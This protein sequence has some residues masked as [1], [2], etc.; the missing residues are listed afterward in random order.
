MSHFVVLVIG[1]NLE[2]KLAP[3]NEEKQVKPYIDTKREEVEETFRKIKK[4][5]AMSSFKQFQSYLDGWR[6]QKR[7][8]AYLRKY[9]SKMS[10]SE[11]VDE[12]YGQK[13]DENGNL[14]TTYNP[15]SKWDWYQI[16]GR[17]AGML[18]LKEDAQGSVG[19]PSLLMNDFKYKPQ[20]A[21]SGR[22][23]DIDWEAMQNN[24]EEEKRLRDFW[25]IAT[26]KDLSG[27]E[28]INKGVY[29]TPQY[30]LDMYKT[31]DEY[32]RR[33]TLFSTYAVITD[34][35]KWHG[36]GDMG[37]FGMSSESDEEAVDWDNG[38]WDRFLADMEPD[39]LI[40]I[41]DCHI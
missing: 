20:E 9:S 22:F 28:R 19:R 36:K 18:L 39:T 7:A 37:W 30:Y 8:P 12:Y 23:D 34:D 25:K 13:M 11:F 16:G 1:E 27:E 29:L 6:I 31:E 26:D 4:E 10:L 5:A 14:L 33:L 35:G 24:P 40:T 3:Y 17:W 41:L 2:E 21:D 32:V 15:D 38:Y